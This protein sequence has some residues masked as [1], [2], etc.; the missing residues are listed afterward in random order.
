MSGKAGVFLR[1]SQ[2]SSG[3]ASWMSV[4]EVGSGGVHSYKGQVGRQWSGRV[5]HGPGS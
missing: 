3:S 4:E 5:R 1:N 2:L